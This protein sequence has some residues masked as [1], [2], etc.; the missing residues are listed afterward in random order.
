MYIWKESER[1]S[2]LALLR[3]SLWQGVP[4]W[5]AAPV[6]GPHLSPQVLWK[7]PEAVRWVWEGTTSLGTKG[8]KTKRV[9]FPLKPSPT[10]PVNISYVAAQSDL[11]L[12]SS[13]E[14][15]YFSH[16]APFSLSI[17]LQIIFLIYYNNLSLL[18]TICHYENI[19]LLYLLDFTFFFW[20]S[21]H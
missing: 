14:K 11:H 13:K 17:S 20:V 15:V 12:E 8:L 19:L 9:V 2:K 3:C 16:L 18:L 1:A 5:L 7:W 10:S 4:R 21:S 6:P